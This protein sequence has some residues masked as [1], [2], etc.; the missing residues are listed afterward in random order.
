MFLGEKEQEDPF[1]PGFERFKHITRHYEETGDW[2]WRGQFTKPD[3]R[4]DLHVPVPKEP[5]SWLISAFSVSRNKGLGV[6]RKPTRV[7]AFLKK[8]SFN[9]CV[10][11][12]SSQVYRYGHALL[13]FSMADLWR[14]T[15]MQSVGRYMKFFLKNPPSFLF[16]PG[17][18][19]SVGQ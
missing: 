2:L 8:N 15:L 10:V 12:L 3:G 17:N 19:E 4:L 13:I 6:T 16:Y 11:N 14:G 9:C 18:F 7:R 1:T 5:M